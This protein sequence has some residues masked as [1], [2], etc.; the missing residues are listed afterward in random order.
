MNQ[1]GRQGKSKLWALMMGALV[2][3]GCS[4]FDVAKKEEAKLAKV[5][6][7]AIELAINNAQSSLDYFTISVRK[8]DGEA[9]LVRILPKGKEGVHRSHWLKG[10]IRKPGDRWSGVYAGGSKSPNGLK[11]GQVVQFDRKQIIDWVI[12]RDGIRYGGF[13]EVFDNPSKSRKGSK[14]AKK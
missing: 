6:G 3:H 10:V 9:F 2:C 13:T 8:R 5:R 11:P 12:V 7:T 14:V 1:A 4:F